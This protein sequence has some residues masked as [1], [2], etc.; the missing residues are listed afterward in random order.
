[1]TETILTI[2]NNLNLLVPIPCH[3]PDI[4]L[5]VRQVQLY[6]K[7]VHMLECSSSQPVL[8]SS[9]TKL[10]ALYIDLEIR[11]IQGVHQSSFIY[12]LFFGNNKLELMEHVV[13]P[14][15]TQ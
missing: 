2:L 4:P 9:R 10:M 11:E 7:L 3:R 14:S 12:S 13:L 5:C 1:M 15:D 6:S 8:E